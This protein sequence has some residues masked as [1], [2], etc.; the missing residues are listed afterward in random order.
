MN[1]RKNL[2]HGAMVK[3]RAVQEVL[4]RWDPINVAPSTVAPADEYE[5]YAPHIVSM[6]EGG[7]TIDDLAAHLEHLCVRTMGLGPSSAQSRSHSL[8]FTAQIVDK[9]RPVNSP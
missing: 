9:L 4:R 1:N 6:V 3:I 5:S 8:K 2:K 7:C